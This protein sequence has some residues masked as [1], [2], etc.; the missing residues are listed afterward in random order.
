M[1]PSMLAEIRAA[2]SGLP[3]A[4][5]HAPNQ[6]IAEDEV[7]TVQAHRGALSP[8]RPLVVGNRGMGKSFWAH[9]LL[10]E[11]VRTRVAHELHLP[12]LAKATVV[13]GFSGSAA[14]D[15][16]APT[17]A[18]LGGEPVTMWRTVL[19]RAIAHI[20]GERLPGGFAE[21]LVWVDRNPEA[22]SALLRRGDQHLAANRAH[23][24]ILFDALDRL[25]RDW[26]GMRERLQ[27][28]LQLV[29][30]VASLRCIRLKLFLRSDQF[31][32]PRLFAFPDASKIRNASV[33]LTWPIEDLYR[34]LFFQLSGCEAFRALET[35]ILRDEGKSTQALVEA[36]AGRFMG[37]N[38]KRGLVY[39]W[40]PTHLAD[41]RGD[42]SPRTFL[43]VWQGAASYGA[44]PIDTP[45]DHLS[46]HEGVRRASEARLAELSED[47]PWVEAALAPLR[48]QEVPI[49]RAVLESL[50]REASTFERVMEIARS[51]DRLIFVPTQLDLFERQVT[52]PE[53][54]LLLALEIIGVIAIRSTVH[55]IDVPDIFRV[56]AKIKR[57][58]GVQPKRRPT[59]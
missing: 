13:F 41:A 30:E 5:H 21:Q 1:T 39:T 51:R 32:D 38:K 10:N 6:P 45:I 26:S 23:V 33:K 12:E 42:I 27:A 29:L 49:R 15:P 7:Y 11:A 46:I 17:P 35:H 48:G 36:L 18:M 2:L 20:L 55:T 59:A 28:L 53:G 4:P 16:I 54:E 37:T 25:G 40:L 58:G 9:A 8:D 14:E 19:A 44:P 34:L 57:R 56:E 31:A 24:L 47:Y 52:S 43:T 50:W 22:Y 3:I